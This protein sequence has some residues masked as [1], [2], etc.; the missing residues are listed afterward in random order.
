MW[1]KVDKRQLE[2]LRLY[3]PLLSIVKGTE[4]QAAPLTIRG[5]TVIVP[6]QTRVILNLNALHSHPRYW[7]DD[8][9]EYKPSRWIQS[10]PGEGAVHDREQ[11]ILPSHGAYLPW[12]EGHRACPGKKFAQVEHVAVMVAMFR[13]HYVA[14]LRR[15]GESQEA[16]R[17]RAA[18][19]VRDTGMLLLLQMLHPERTPLV[20]KER[21]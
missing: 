19:S 1:D 9:L 12:G 13:D 21:K 6:P 17:E 3:D 14:P 4:G 10:T 18:A 16:A 7:G 5:Q 15:S 2:T 8:G 11:L 20:W